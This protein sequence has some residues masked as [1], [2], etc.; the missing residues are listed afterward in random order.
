MNPVNFF[1]LNLS[2]LNHANP[3]GVTYKGVTPVHLE[4]LKELARARSSRWPNDAMS[5]QSRQSGRHD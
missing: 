3:F 1:F 4:R 5:Y 2:F